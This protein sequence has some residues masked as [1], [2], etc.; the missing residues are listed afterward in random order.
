MRLILVTVLAL[1]GGLLITGCAGSKT[2]SA[3]E[4]AETTMAAAAPRADFAGW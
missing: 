1:G 3:A 4:S 2:N